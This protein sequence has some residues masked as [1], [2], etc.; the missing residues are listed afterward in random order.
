MIQINQHKK[1]RYKVAVIK[2]DRINRNRKLED[3]DIGSSTS[4]KIANYEPE[5]V[6]RSLNERDRLKES[7]LEKTKKGFQNTLIYNTIGILIVYLAGYLIV[8]YFY[9]HKR[10]SCQPSTD[11]QNNL[12][13]PSLPNSEHVSTSKNNMGLVC[14]FVQKIHSNFDYHIKATTQNE[15]KLLILMTFLIGFYVKKM[16]ERWWAQVSGI[17]NMESLCLGM[18][19]MGTS[20]PEKGGEDGLNNFK[21]RIAR[22]VLLSWTM[23]LCGVMPRCPNG[24]SRPMRT[25]DS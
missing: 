11:E 1:Q 20:V 14:V 25:P 17:P 19:G 12:P 22:Y 16:M 18:N 15:R 23:C 2:E 7:L 10:R 24:L 5:V 13:S 4:P 9:V 6:R 21:T 3:Y 8:H